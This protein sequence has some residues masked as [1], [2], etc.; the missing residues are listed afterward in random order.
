MTSSRT[1]AL[2][3]RF[4]VFLFEVNFSMSLSLV[5]PCK[6]ASTEFT[7]EGLFPR[8]CAD[9]RGQVVAAAE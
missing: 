1:T 4:L 7:G 9:V 6:L 2:I 5:A 8:V 3:G